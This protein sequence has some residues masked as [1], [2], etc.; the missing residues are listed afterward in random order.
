MPAIRRHIQPYIQI[1]R[2]DHWVKQIFVLPGILLAALFTHPPIQAI[3]VPSIIGLISV[4][5]IAS[6]NYTINEWLDAQ[7]DRFHPKKKNRPSVNNAVK[8]RFVY[9][10][11]FL[12]VLS[13]LSIAWFVS[14]LFFF[15]SIFLLVMGVIYNVKPFRTKDMVFLDVITESINNPTRLLL[16]WFIVN[17]AI[18]PPSTL[19]LAFFFGG[20]FLMAAKRYAEYVFIND[21]Q[22]A[23]LYRKS[24][25][26]Y[27][28]DSLLVSAFFYALCCA[29]F[30]GVFMIK[31]KIELII[32]FPFL[33]GLFSWYLYLALKPD[34]PTQH[35]EGLYF[36][37][38]FVS[39]SIFVALLLI[40]LLVI[41]IP[42]LEVLTENVFL[43]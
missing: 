17:T 16:G 43:H 35:P 1:A 23:G 27:T 39:Y 31:Y 6:A 13:G 11:Y 34:S 15:T 4:C 29:F 2:P 10:E 9:L 32:S 5:L 41:H 28:K 25:L 12:L 14:S 37:K 33:A 30:L 40:L 7:F 22:T 20:A 26:H 38:R 42:Q 24:F 19:V 3:I 8:A 21:P 18:I 36:G